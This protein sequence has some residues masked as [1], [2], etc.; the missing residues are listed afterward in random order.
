MQNQ[1]DKIQSVE[2][3]RIMAER[4][5]PKAL[6]QM[7]SG[8]SGPSISLRL[9][10]QAFEEVL[11]R[12]HAAVFHP[13]RELKTTLLGH[14]ISMPVILSSVG[15]LKVGHVDGEA[16]VAR[17][18]GDAGTIQILSGAT[19]TP[20][21][22]V[23]AA[24]SGP[25]FQ[26]LYYIGG[27]ENSAQIIERAKRAGAAALVVVVDSAAPN[28]GADIPYTDRA[29]LPAGVTLKDALRFAPQLLTKPAW[30]RDF[31]RQGL[32][33]PTAGMAMRPDGTPMEWLEMAGRLYDETPTFEDLPWIR[34]LWDGPIVL[35]G[36]VRGDDARR[37]VELG[38]DGIIVSNHGG[39]MLDSTV[40]TLRALPEVVAAVDGRAEVI[41]DGGVRRGSDVVKA[42]ALGAKAVSLGRAYVYPLLAAGEPGVRR[43]LEIFRR[44]IDSTLGWLGVRSVHDLD[45]SLLELPADWPQAREGV[46]RD[47]R[48]QTAAAA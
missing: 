8:G 28:V 25:V 20:I 41:L 14:D 7:F 45:P 46:D 6:F 34:E 44:Q 17:A 36:I 26:Q 22:E 11:F 4:R 19:I 18:A 48:V 5:V 37:A 32:K 2:D 3:A 40:P 42:L 9:N 39:N 43:I 12:P 30:T 10:E 15:M 29:Y 33:T 1:V 35:K 23:V 24:A 31:I 27:R 38:V 13:E 47:A 21:E 16:G